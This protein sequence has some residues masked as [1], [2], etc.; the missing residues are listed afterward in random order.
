MYMKREEEEQERIVKRFPNLFRNYDYLG[1]GSGWYP[2]IERLAEKLEPMIVKFE[3]EHPNDEPA[4]KFISDIKEKYG[5]LRFYADAYIFNDER[6]I[7]WDK[8][9]NDAEDEAE[10]TCEKCGKPGQS[11]PGGWILTLC[12]KCHLARKGEYQNPVGDELVKE[13]VL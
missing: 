9:I 6:D 13:I 1:V 2:L 10:V 12:N 11:R 4:S 8:A 7:A 5:G 3:A